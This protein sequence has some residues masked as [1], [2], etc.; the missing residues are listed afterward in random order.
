MDI[1]T[2]DKINDILS[3]LNLNEVTEEEKGIEEI[4]KYAKEK[5]DIQLP[6]GFHLSAEI[7]ILL[8][9]KGIAYISNSAYHTFVDIQLIYLLF[10]KRENKSLDLKSICNKL[11]IEEKYLDK[12]EVL[13][14]SHFIIQDFPYEFDELFR[15]AYINFLSELETKK[16]NQVNTLLEEVNRL[17]IENDGFKSELTSLIKTNT[18]L[19]ENL[20]NT[21]TSIISIMGIFVCIFSLI[22]ININ[23]FQ[24][25]VDSFGNI[26]QVVALFLI[27]NSTMLIVLIVLLRFIYIFF[28]KVS[29]IEKDDAQ[30]KKE[31]QEEENKKINEILK[32]KY[33]TVPIILFSIG[34]ALLLY[35]LRNNNA[36]QKF[37]N[38]DRTEVHIQL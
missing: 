1:L 38:N 28:Y 3:K 14:F 8:I 36:N 7:N 4:I 11:E 27:I 23:F 18:K 34:I 26:G 6:L 21:N 15:K 31:K 19:E 2:L 37:Q 9:P 12:F 17:K 33:Y 32:I 22:S 30:N 10:Y 5:L 29:I 35:T 25:L 24:T 16:I 13:N 20:K